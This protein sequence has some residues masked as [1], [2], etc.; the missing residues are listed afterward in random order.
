MCKK[1]CRDA[2]GYKCHLTS[3]SHQRQLLLVAEDTDKYVREFSRDFENN[4]LQVLKNQFGTK[5]VL[6]NEVY[7]EIIREKVIVQFSSS[8][9]SE[10]QGHVHMNS[11]RWHS[12]SA[13]V[14]HLGETEKCKIDKHDEKGRVNTHNFYYEAFRL[15]YPVDRSRGG[16]E[17]RGTGEESE[18]WEGRRGEAA[19]A[20]PTTG[21][22]VSRTKFIDLSGCLGQKGYLEIN[23]NIRRRS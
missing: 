2:N 18:G 20:H 15:V 22:T 10:L 21:W 23:Q 9:E 13:F 14:Q 4:F 3:E 12:L 19:G 1:Q 7:Q 11:T 5:R 16:V 8:K 6:A 17:E